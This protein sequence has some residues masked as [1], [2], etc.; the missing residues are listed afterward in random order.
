M[1][2]VQQGM[3]GFRLAVGAVGLETFLFTFGVVQG[4]GVVAARVVGQRVQ[5]ASGRQYWLQRHSQGEQTH[6]QQAQPLQAA[7][8]TT[9]NHGC[10][11]PGAAPVTQLRSLPGPKRPIMLDHDPSPAGAG[12]E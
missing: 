2:E 7:M 12:N 1:R 3:Q 5:L 11:V 10:R 4:M 6:R 9:R 8:G